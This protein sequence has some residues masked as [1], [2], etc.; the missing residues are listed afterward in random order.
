ML[1]TPLGNLAGA[2]FHQDFDLEYDA[3]IEA[4]KDCREVGSAGPVDA[5][6]AALRA[7]LDAGTPE[8]KLAELWLEEGRAYYDPRGDGM[9]IRK[10]PCPRG[11]PV[12][13]G[14]RTCPHPAG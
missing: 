3:P 9:A 12:R 6:R 1:S 11:G 13:S 8:Q 14:P 4:L 7:L 10:R 2:Y 5:L